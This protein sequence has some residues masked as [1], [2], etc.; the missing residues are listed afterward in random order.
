VTN[1]L[2]D[3]IAKPRIAGRPMRSS[4]A[5]KAVAYQKPVEEKAPAYGDVEGSLDATPERLAKSNDNFKGNDGVRRFA[6]SLLVR[7]A[8]RGGLYPDKDINRAL[9]QAGERYYADWYGSNMSPLKAFDPTRVYTGAG[10]ASAMPASVAQA[11]KRK[12]HRKARAYLGKKYADALE[13]MVLNEQTDLV[14]VGQK[15][16]RVAHQR[17]ARAIATE[18]LTAGLFLLAKHYGFIS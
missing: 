13:L 7:L 4:I 3:F 6:D 11:Q 17:A 18:R 16:G 15:I 1:A 14:A 12:E 9:L 5:R 2:P 10:D 8:V